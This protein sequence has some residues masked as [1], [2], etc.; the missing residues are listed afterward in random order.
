M[1]KLNC[2]FRKIIEPTEILCLIDGGH[3]K[4]DKSFASII[5]I[6]NGIILSRAGLWIIDLT[7]TQLHLDTIPEHERVKCWGNSVC[8]E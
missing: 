7:V 3:T 4:T 8:T 1:C 6:L 2:I 5:I